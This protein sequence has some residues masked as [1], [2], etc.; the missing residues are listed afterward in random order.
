[1]IRSWKLRIAISLLLAA[2]PV[3]ASSGDAAAI[4]KA[5]IDYWRDVSS[6]SLSEMVIHRPEWQRGL[7]IRVWT[8]GQKESLVRV[9]SPPKDAGSSTL[10]IDNEMWSFS[11]KINRVIKVPPSMMGQNW[12]GSDF[13][14]SDLAKADDL[15]KYYTHRILRTEE[16][17]GHRVYVIESIPK[18]SAP[19]V[20]GKEV[21]VIR[22]DHVLLEH[23]YYDQD[24]V[25]VKNLETHELKTFD[26]KVVPTRQRMQKAD[27]P[28]EWTEIVVKEAKFRQD[29]PAK[30]FTLSNLRNPRE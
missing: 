18:E 25:L 6:Y 5:A 17:D 20:W 14:N 7:T 27:K 16:R 29:I 3:A 10:L 12:M 21:V 23:A 19:V 1:M 13:S 26:D 22:D 9:V 30:V 4:V 8:K 11:P 28:G 2:I 15:L 24:M